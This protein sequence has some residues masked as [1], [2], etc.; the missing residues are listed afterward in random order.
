MNQEELAVQ[1]GPYKVLLTCY[2]WPPNARPGQKEFIAT[3]FP[4][5]APWDQGEAATKIQA[6][7]RGRNVAKSQHR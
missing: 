4:S 3:A 2:R 1:T 6:Q 5:D 7:V